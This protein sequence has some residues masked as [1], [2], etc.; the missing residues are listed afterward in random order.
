[1][2]TTQ[3]SRLIN[4]SPDTLFHAFTDP[5]A[6]ESWMAPGDMTAK[7]HS[8]DLS[9]GGGY[10]MSLYYPGGSASRGKTTQG[11]DRYTARFITLQPNKRIVL[12]IRFD[13]AGPG[14]VGE[15]VMEVRFEPRGSATLVTI[16]FTNIPLG[17]RPEDNEKG[18]ELS[19]DNLE[20]YVGSAPR[21]D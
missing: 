12:G 4:A 7:V 13:S 11:E 16:I 20:R 10:V 2:T 15:M 17:I 6:L 19:L 3:S 14:Y 8:F 9:V 5:V 18:T 1:M 21:Q